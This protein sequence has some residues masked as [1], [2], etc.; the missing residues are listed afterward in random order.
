MTKCFLLLLVVVGL[1]LTLQVGN[2]D[3]RFLDRGFKYWLGKS[4]MSNDLG[5]VMQLALILATRSQ[6]G[7]VLDIFSEKG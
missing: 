2:N 3:L 7:Q 5:V 6:S 1:V 4:N